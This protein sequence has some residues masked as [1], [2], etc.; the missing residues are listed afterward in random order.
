MDPGVVKCEKPHLVVY[1]WMCGGVR[2]KL[3]DCNWFKSRE[4]DSE[5]YVSAHSSEVDIW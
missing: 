5:P 4:R 3:C 2:K 1:K